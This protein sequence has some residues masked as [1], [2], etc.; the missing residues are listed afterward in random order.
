MKIISSFSTFAI[1]A[2]ACQLLLAQAPPATTPVRPA[3]ATGLCKDGTYSSE[4]VKSGACHSHHGVKEWY[5]TTPATPTPAT[6]SA[7]TTSAATTS[8]TTPR[9]APPAT[10]GTPSPTTQ[11]RSQS[12]AAAQQA[13]QSGEPLETQSINKGSAANAASTPT[14]SGAGPGMVW[15]KTGSKIYHCPGTR[16]YGKTKHGSYM[17]EADAKAKGAHIGRGEVCTL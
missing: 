15:L 12:Q 2:L 17:S 8:A 3:D 5:D 4:A 6:P 14:A 11:A 7:A 10:A 1:G 9:S 13:G 16:Y